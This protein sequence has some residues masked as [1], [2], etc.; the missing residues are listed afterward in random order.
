VK[1]SGDIGVWVGAITAIGIYSVLYK[2]NP[3]YRLVE[4]IFIGASAGIAVVV[5][6]QTFKNTAWAPMLKGNYWLI[7]AM[8]LGLLLYARYFQSISWL[9]RLPLSLLMGTS[10]GVAMRGAVE[11]QI[12]GQIGAT[13]VNLRSVN[14]WIIFLG[15][16]LSL[17]Y[18]FLTW[19]LGGVSGWAPKW[20]RY[21]MMAAFGASF[22]NTVM[23]R[24]SAAIG[25]FQFIFLMWLGM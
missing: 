3:F 22:G 8:L 25:R 10:A 5:G 7:V 2:D 20:G 17:S 11:S 24:V 6:F 4:H 14:A 19:K 21:F 13:M 16:I 15:T 18:F 12:V 23:G 1:I 9:N